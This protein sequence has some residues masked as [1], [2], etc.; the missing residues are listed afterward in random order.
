MGQRLMRAIGFHGQSANRGQEPEGHVPEG[1]GDAHFFKHRVSV[2]D[3][4]RVESSKKQQAK[5]A[6]SGWHAEGVGKPGRIRQSYVCALRCLGVRDGDGTGNPLAS[7]ELDHIPPHLLDL[8]DS[9]CRSEYPDGSVRSGFGYC[10]LG[11][12]RFRSFPDFPSR[13]HPVYSPSTCVLIPRRIQ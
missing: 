1:K 7:R 10:S 6:T 9:S 2:D 8:R 12:F 5:S 11:E 13:D 3:H 4:L